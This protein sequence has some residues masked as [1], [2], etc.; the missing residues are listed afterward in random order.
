MRGG[1]LLLGLTLA[2]IP[3]V[4]A[5]P[6]LPY[7]RMLGFVPL[8]GALLGTLIVVT[9]LWAGSAEVLKWWFYRHER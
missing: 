6:W 1:A 7:A 9:L 4:I 5:I 3:V 8:P 2:L